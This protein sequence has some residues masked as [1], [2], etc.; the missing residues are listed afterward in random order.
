MKALPLRLL[1][2]DDLRA[3]REA[4]VAAHDSGAAFV[5]SGIGSLSAAQLRFAGATEPR[6][7]DDALEI[8]TLAGTVSVSGSHLHMSVADAHGHVLGGH[9]GHG[10]I[11]RTTAEVLLVLMSEWSFSRERDPVTGYRE[12]VMHPKR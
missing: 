8:L 7:L 12:L 2:G 11:V 10:C 5:L 4:A 6:W 3:A 1:P 9:V